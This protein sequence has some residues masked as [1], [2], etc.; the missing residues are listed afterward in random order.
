MSNANEEYPRCTGSAFPP[1]LDACCGSRMFWFNKQD[2][3]AIFLDNRVAVHRMPPWGRH[4]DGAE[5]RVQPD[6][7]ADFTDQPFQ[8][9]TFA[10]VV[11]DPPHMESIGDNSRTAHKYGKLFGD[12]RDMLRKGFDECFRVL[13][14]EGTLIFKWCEYEVP[15]AEVLALTN[16][17]PLFGHK[18]GKQQKTHW[19][20]FLK[21]N[22]H[23]PSV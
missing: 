8:D 22:N 21:P 9:N 15:L 18:S 10:L 6:Q 14:P 7:V 17:R 1:V 2:E 3:R 23:S 20:A 19:I 5:I 16:H 4:W 12:W 11:F 13:R